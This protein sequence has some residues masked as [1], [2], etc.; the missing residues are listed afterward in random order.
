MA[1]T[2][3]TLA[4]HP[5]LDVAIV[6]ADFD[7]VRPLAQALFAHA[8]R[9]L[10][11]RGFTWK[12]RLTLLR[13]RARGINFIGECE[14]RIIAPQDQPGMTGLKTNGSTAILSCLSALM[15][16]AQFI[17]F[18]SLHEAERRQRH[19]LY[20]RTAGRIERRA[21]AS[22]GFESKGWIW[23]DVGQPEAW[24]QTAAH[25]NTA[26][27]KRQNRDTLIAQM[28]ALGFD[29]SLLLD[30]ASAART[31]RFRGGEGAVA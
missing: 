23:E 9:G 5:Q 21:V 18:E 26:I 13:H 15:P 11:L 22:I 20:V 7:E 30:S 12:Q 1:A 27:Q 10:S 3:L 19:G 6:L 29:P 28:Q 4:E 2:H 24:E 17:E 8:R 16:R 25:Q 31:A 14:M